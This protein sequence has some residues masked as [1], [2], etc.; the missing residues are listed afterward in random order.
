M[1]VGEIDLSLVL[2]SKDFETQL[3]NTVNKT[4]NKVQKDVNK[5]VDNTVKQ[6]T[7]KIQN[8]FDPLQN[9]L[10]NTVKSA[11]NQL[12]NEV[13]GTFLNMGNEL[14][15]TVD[16]AVNDIEKEFNG[17]ELNFDNINYSTLTQGLNDVTG[18]IK[19][20]F[21]ELEGDASKLGS[22]FNDLGADFRQ[23]FDD[24]PLAVDEAGNSFEELSSDAT[25][26]G[27]VIDNLGDNFDQVGDRL[28]D[29]LD[30]ISDTIN[31]ESEQIETSGRRLRDA[32][33]GIGD[34]LENSTE[35]LRDAIRDADN[36]VGGLSNS[37]ED[38]GDSTQKGANL[39]GEALEGLGGKAKRIAGI[40][41]TA[42]AFDQLK[43]AVLECAELGSDLDE[44]G[45]V[46]DT[47]FT[48]MNDKV[49]E[50]S[51]N[52]M[53]QFGMSETMTMN[54]VGTLGSMARAFD[55]TEAQA[56]EMATT[57]SGL[58]GDVASFYN[59]DHEEA[60]TKL[61]SVFT[62][63]TEALKELGIVMTQTALDEY[64]LAHGFGKTTSKM[65]EQEKTA[66]RYKFVLDKLKFAQGDFAKT[67]DGWA[68]QM[69]VFQLQWESLKGTLGRGFIIVLTPIL[70]MLNKIIARIIEMA[71]LFVQAISNIK[72]SLG[73]LGGATVGKIKT[74][75]S[76]VVPKLANGGY[77]KKNNPQLAII[78]DNTHEGEIV[79]PESKISN[80]VSEGIKKVVSKP[81][82]K[83]NEVDT[84]HSELK[85]V[86]S[87]ENEK[88]LTKVNDN[89]DKEAKTGEKV[90]NNNEKVIENNTIEKAVPVESKIVENNNTIEKVVPIR[91]NESRLEGVVNNNEGNISN[92]GANSLESDITLNNTNVVKTTNN[93]V[94]NKLNNDKITDTAVNTINDE[95]SKQLNTKMSDKVMSNEL[96]NT[97][98]L[99][100]VN[101]ENN[102]VKPITIDKNT[103]AVPKLA[104]GGYV[105]KN[106]PQ[107]VMIGDNM[108]EGEIVSPES[109]IINAVS[110]GIKKVVTNDKS[111]T[112]S[113]KVDAP[114]TATSS[115]TTSSKSTSSKSTM[116]FD[117]VNKLGDESK[118]VTN[119][120]SKIGK[121][122]KTI[123][124]TAKKIIND[125]KKALMGFD[126]LNVLSLDEEENNL[127][128]VTDPL[129]DLEDLT[130]SIP[131]I[132]DS[133]GDSL[134][135]TGL[136]GLSDDLKGIDSDLKGLGDAGIGDLV[137]GLDDATLGAGALNQELGEANGELS[138]ADKMAGALKD[139]LGELAGL[140]KQGFNLG[141][142][143]PNFDNITEHARGVMGSL[144]AIFTDPMLQKAVDDFWNS[145]VYN[146]GQILGSLASVGLTAVELLVGGM[147]LYLAKNKG[148]IRD[149]FVSEFEALAD[150]FDII[151]STFRDVA[152]IFTVF[153]SDEAKSILA[154]LIE[155]FSNTFMGIIE[156]ATKFGR[157]VLNAVTQ[158]IRDNKD[159]IKELLMG[160]LKTIE[161][162]VQGMADFVTHAMEKVNDVYDKH[163]KPL[164]DSIGSL[165]SGLLGTI[166]DNINNFL[167]PLL[168]LVGKE[169]K[170]VFD[171]YI[172]PVF[173]QVM[174]IV[175][176]VA[177]I[178]SV[179]IEYG[180]KPMLQ[181]IVDAFAPAI[182]VALGGAF[183]IVVEAVKVVMDVI[184]D[185]LKIIEGLLDFIL[186][187]FTND[188]DLAWEGLSYAV[189]SAFALIDNLTGGLLSSL[190]DFVASIG[191]WFVDAYHSIQ[192]AFDGAGEWAN[193]VG[194]SIE[195][196]FNNCMANV[197]Q[198]FSQKYEDMKK[199]F[200]GAGEWA[201]GVGK[202]MKAGI[203]TGFGNMTAFM[204]E[205][206]SEM[207]K[208]F[209]GVNS[210]FSEKFGQARNSIMAQF[211]GLPSWFS[212]LWSNIRASFSGLG[213][214]LGNMIGGAVKNAVNYVLALCEN[215]INSFISLF[216]GIIK[217]VNKLPGVNV[218]AMN[219][220]S[221]PRL[222]EG[223]YVRANTPQLAVIGDNKREGEI[224]APESKIAEAVAQGV[225]VAFEK[226]IGLI[227]NQNDN[228]GSQGDIIIPVSI[229]QEHIDT[230]IINS[231][232]RQTL[233]S[234]GRV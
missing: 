13:S 106:K 176:Q 119:N 92:E 146:S 64:A 69:R 227:N 99:E 18:E 124:N 45:N 174:D 211:K 155:I 33:N 160:L 186:G 117:E 46:V 201:K 159:K 207:K 104:K 171:N 154:G 128:S 230:I 143:T 7:G 198:W 182:G 94:A 30:G 202:S 73:G 84:K 135:D 11:T 118:E 1:N 105:K 132:S 218:G 185:F 156:L 70:T 50:F 41:G 82:S 168:E 71:N 173:D 120:T 216:N 77:F 16:G 25:K 98:S 110:E 144:R 60:F 125:S 147:D 180:L 43:D 151:G 65:T 101:E 188:W 59:I 208:S 221:L 136:K 195:A 90:I 34:G 8:A 170:K 126:E 141:L 210:W 112:V 190:A 89:K 214:R 175:G 75:A 87:S 76:K 38:I 166:L 97:M 32:F 109:K 9:E 157:D 191:Q 138:T 187:A 108:R 162:I 130:S 148:F 61:K 215:K 12:N 58:A 213:T 234:G 140:F 145:L 14:A 93:E 169:V 228:R 233:R 55:F 217:Y 54:Y 5:G 4:V 67:S 21:A 48:S 194:K 2:T 200:N 66:L 116:N 78:G 80:A 20:S 44:V 56:Y 22:S 27:R 95:I 28:E 19:S 193:G 6:T 102:K 197:G 232:R 24:I 79:A 81:T 10:N 86:I 51:Q 36:E 222:A 100:K 179:L 203:K 3:N 192:R 205:R 107:L 47:V 53:M 184:S 129:K 204:S 163:L 223:G 161:P 226:V 134:G 220:V 15:Q 35:G 165:L 142:G 153:R 164:V 137:K 72:K 177:D 127:D 113:V 88:M 29:D 123:G 37:L 167:M 196:G 133:L 158:P 68:N 57:L 23:S 40:I 178:L 150:I 26:L 74:T 121:T 31:R 172:S 114:K 52:A 139:R 224:V 42:F 212:G 152:D 219:K 62:G 209:S 131:D 103:N 49:R 189:S 17:I 229:G 122:V 183:V 115:K 63:E 149:F 91:D 181:F 83:E 85:K 199:A 225:A 96:T 231:Q 206:W 39:G 111:K